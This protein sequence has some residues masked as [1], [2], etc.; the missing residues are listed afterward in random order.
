LS[1][2][3]RSSTRTTTALALAGAIL[4]LASIGPSKGRTRQPASRPKKPAS[5]PPTRRKRAREEEEEEKENDDDDDEDDEAEDS[6]AWYIGY[7]DDDPDDEWV[8]SAGEK[9]LKKKIENQKIVH[10]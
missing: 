8:P 5:R 3:R 7:G 4:P 9:K 2:S 10:V 6:D 1:S